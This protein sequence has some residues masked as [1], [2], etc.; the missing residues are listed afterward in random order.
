M[1]FLVTWLWQGLAISCV[2]AMAIRNMPRL[3]AATRHVIW[4]LALAGV[5][6]IPVAHGLVAMIP[7]P[8]SAPESTG[9]LNVARS[10]LL[11]TI[12][13]GVVNAAAALWAMTAA[14][15][16]LRL[17][18]GHRAL[19][20]LKHTAS[21]F[22]PSREARLR[23]RSAARNSRRR[24]AELRTADGVTGACAL[25]LGQPTIL[26]SRA[27]ADALDDQ[28]LD[29]IVMHEQAHLDRYDDWSQLVLAALRSLAGLHPAVR[30]LAGRVQ[31]DLEA[32]CDDRVVS[33]TGAPRHYASSLLTVAA[34]SNPLAERLQLAAGVPAATATASMLRARIARLL[35]T[36]RDRSP[37]LAR[38]T[39]LAA[40]ALLL[41]ALVGSKQVHPIVTFVESVVVTNQAG[42]AAPAI[43]PQR[44]PEPA[45]HASVDATADASPRALRRMLAAPERTTDADPLPQGVLHGVASASSENRDEHL[46]APLDSLALPAETHAVVPGVVVPSWQAM[47]TPSDPM[48]E[49]PWQAFAT[50]ATTAASDVA[51][52]AAATGARVQGAGT[53][54]SRF[55]TRVSKAASV[56]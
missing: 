22:D 46:S 12:P 24:V 40:V 49:A 43:V 5:L 56:F 23:L 38:V 55:V 15:G 19:R 25:G 8:A 34:L 29:E 32:A 7:G 21:P 44:A 3:N 52:S 42:D 13:T 17:A 4:W 53:A 48:P 26:I 14:G 18:R 16:L 20:R 30:F 54:I 2:T 37:R 10:L 50:S 47:A 6:A 11:P 36:R 45:I 39:S 28:S 9:A 33:Q 1:T 35:D 41:L 51:R 27:V 31:V